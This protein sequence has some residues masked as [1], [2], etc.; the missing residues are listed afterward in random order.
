MAARSLLHVN[1]SEQDQSSGPHSAMTAA[2]AES[3]Q[4]FTTPIIARVLPKRLF[5]ENPDEQ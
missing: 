4:R 5:G 1:Y 2:P 3:F